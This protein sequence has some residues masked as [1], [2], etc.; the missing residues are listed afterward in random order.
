MYMDIYVKN[1]YDCKRIYLHTM[2][3]LHIVYYVYDSHNS[4]YLDNIQYYVC[5]VLL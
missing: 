4:D 5:A 2:Y 3:V 1:E